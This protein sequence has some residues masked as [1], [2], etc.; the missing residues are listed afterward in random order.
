[1][2]RMFFLA[3]L[4]MMVCASTAH[5]WA[6]QK[7]PLMEKIDAA[8]MKSSTLLDEKKYAEA[9]KA[10]NE[11]VEY[12]PQPLKETYKPYAKTC[13]G[14][15]SWY[16]TLNKQYALAA[17]AAKKALTFATSES[18]T[19][20][21][22]GNLAHA[23]LMSG[24]TQE[25]E[26]IYRKH[27]DKVF[28]EG[29]DAQSWSQIVLGDFKIMREAGIDSPEMATIEKIL[30]SRMIKLESA[31]IVKS[32]GIPIGE[33]D[34]VRLSPDKKY[35]AIVTKIDLNT[36]QVAV[37][38]VI[39]AKQ[40]LLQQ[41]P[42]ICAVEFSPDSKNLATLFSDR[43]KG[44][45]QNDIFQYSMKVDLTNIVSG[46]TKLIVAKKTTN[47]YNMRLPKGSPL[48]KYV[49]SFAFHPN[50]TTIALCE[51]KDSFGGNFLISKLEFVTFPKVTFEIQPF[52]PDFDPPLYD[53]G[54][55]P[56]LDRKNNKFDYNGYFKNAVGSIRMSFSDNGEILS[57]WSEKK[58]NNPYETKSISPVKIFN[59]N[60]NTNS[61]TGR[62]F[63]FS[64]PKLD[65]AEDK[66]SEVYRCLVAG[67]N[68]TFILRSNKELDGFKYENRSYNLPS[69]TN[70]IQI[71][72]NVLS[73]NKIPNFTDDT[74]F[75]NISDDSL[76]VYKNKNIE[77]ISLQSLKVGER[78]QLI[79]TQQSAVNCLQTF[80][81]NV[82]K[83]LNKQADETVNGTLENFGI[84]GRDMFR[85]S[86]PPP[87]ECLGVSADYLSG[88]YIEFMMKEAFNAF[89]NKWEREDTM[90]VGI[91]EK[92]DNIV[93]NYKKS[94]SQTEKK[95][96]PL[97]EAMKR[98]YNKQYD[99]DQKQVQKEAKVR[100]QK[101]KSGTR[102]YFGPFQGNGLVIERKG[103]MILV[104]PD[105]GTRNDAKWHNVE[106]F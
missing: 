70:L 40:I 12:L 8:L 84:N 60:E 22:E 101:I 81:E 50:G 10:G 30:N 82:I 43:P 37:Y 92:Y 89:R 23:Y 77:A 29:E 78:A 75:L 27:I 61:T 66:F 100:Q 73:I 39:S 51:G 20:W 86:P 31:A 48:F 26:K 69:G 95:Y 90:G 97:W 6:Q 52:D 9:L 53:T 65:F 14:V 42:D 74:I 98:K 7:T 47:Q 16:L 46:E 21:I 62:D 104:Q 80:T 94:F 57:V 93:K 34:F 33:Y 85:I 88:R 72:N 105:G 13:Y 58:T 71:K 32:A 67:G 87:I 79:Q 3:V 44:T 96:M 17:E 56:P 55:G 49:R 2:K 28:G 64:S 19:E 91:M 59:I 103:N 102:V 35:F 4:A 11:A 76:I 18:S 99:I 25:A 63:G 41:K 45:Y 5:I 24:K 54:I 15:L 1:M 106:D 83:K 68:G 36:D 38:D